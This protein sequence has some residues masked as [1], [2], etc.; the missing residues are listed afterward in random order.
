MLVQK[1]LP[2]E[3]VS[4]YISSTL[5]AGGA[6]SKYILNY[7]A[8]NR[9][10]FSISSYLPN[11]FFPESEAA[12]RAGGLL[13]KEDICEYIHHSITKGVIAIVDDVMACGS[14]IGSD[15][16][17][18]E[19]YDGEIYYVINDRNKEIRDIR[20]RIFASST[21]WHQLI[22]LLRHKAISEPGPYVK[23]IVSPLSREKNDIIE[24][25]LGAFDGEGYI[26]IRRSR[27]RST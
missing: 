19:I 6:L 27:G 13:E 1:K 11:G 5:E 9:S 4:N 23:N 26:H 24:I 16:G 18:V 12:F 21:P 25:V 3:I 20:S 8:N 10:S 17:G 7:L 2:Y 15:D 14:D 22:V